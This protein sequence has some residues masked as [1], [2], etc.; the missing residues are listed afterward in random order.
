[1]SSSRLQLRLICEA[2]FSSRFSYLLRQVSCS[3]ISWLTDRTL[4]LVPSTAHLFPSR[5]RLLEVS[6]FPGGPQERMRSTPGLRAAPR[7][8][9]GFMAQCGRGTSWAALLCSTVSLSDGVPNQ[10]GSSTSL[11]P[12]GNENCAPTCVRSGHVRCS[13]CFCLQPRWHRPRAG[14]SPALLCSERTGDALNRGQPQ[15]AVCQNPQ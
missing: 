6:S 9:R 14:P 8:D 11:L 15:R 12:A 3:S 7:R 4:G 10:Q 2:C 13:H 5:D 1:M